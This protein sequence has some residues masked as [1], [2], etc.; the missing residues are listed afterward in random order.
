[1]SGRVLITVNIVR[2][3]SPRLILQH[4]RRKMF[5]NCELAAKE[6]GPGLLSIFCD[7]EKG[8]YFEQKFGKHLSALCY[9]EKLL[10]R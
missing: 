1:M 3:A 5:E 7:I 6:L 10:K 2:F 9:H 4:N 8:D